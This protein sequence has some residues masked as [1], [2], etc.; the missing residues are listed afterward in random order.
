MLAWMYLEA[1]RNIDRAETLLQQ[2]LDLSESAIDDPA[3]LDTLGWLDYRMHRYEQAEWKLWHALDQTPDSD[4]GYFVT[5]YHL[6]FTWRALGQNTSVDSA[7]I[8][9][10][11]WLS[12]YGEDMLIRK[13]VAMNDDSLLIPKC[14]YLDP[15][16]LEF[17]EIR[18]LEEGWW[19]LDGSP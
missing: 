11:S 5:L 12:D 9:I 3:I 16:W 2:C 13:R 1:N 4:E 18:R 19:R 6:Y 17:F 15:H 7:R 10:N 8:R 14:Q